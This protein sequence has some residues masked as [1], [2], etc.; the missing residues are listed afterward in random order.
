MQK[1]L[2]AWL[3]AI[4][5]LAYVAVFA[6]YPL[7]RMLAASVGWPDFQAEPYQRLW[8]EP[9]YGLIGQR[10]FVFGLEVTLI[11][12]LIGYP[13]A[14][15]LS[16]QA[17]KGRTYL[18][19]AV[20]IPYLTSLLV[21]TYAWILLL[22]DS[23]PI[24]AVLLTLGVI[25][26]PLMLLFTRVGALIGAVHIALPL[27]IL[28][29]YSV[30]RTMDKSLMRAALSL[31]SGPVR[32]F[33]KVY[34][35]Q[36]VPGIVS[37]V[38]LVFVLVLGFYVIPAALGG[39]GDTLLSNVVVNIIQYSQ[40][41]AMASAVSIALLVVTLAVYLGL[42]QFDRSDNRAFRSPGADR[43]A[44]AALA[45]AT[46]ALLRLD[47]LAAVGW[48]LRMGRPDR[49]A[50]A[51][52]AAFTIGCVSILLFLILP[53][54]IVLGMSFS[55]SDVVTFPPQELSLRWYRQIVGDRSW[56]RAFVFSLEMAVPSA[57]CAL[58]LGSLAAYGLVRMRP[59]LAKLIL[60]L[61]L[62]PMIVPSVVTGVG[63]FGIFN[64][65]GILGTK[66]AI[67]LTHVVIGIPYAV[68]ISYATLQRFDRRL[69][70][71]A[72]SLGASH[73]RTVL[74]VVVPIITS[75]LVAAGIF[76]FMS[77]FDEVIKTSFIA[78]VN[79]R[80][81]PLKIWD[82]IVFQ[83]DPSTAA[84]SSLLLFFPLIAFIIL[85]RRIVA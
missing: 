61:L 18:V 37:G 41:F 78:G 53:N 47:R 51:W 67:F 40:D 55:A 85:R 5:A 81:L 20:G 25:D 17:D 13:V 2:S 35:P 59:R 3:L 11:A 23:G 9:S 6:L 66:F 36:T 69:E 8:N 48:R 46:S 84:V 60:A 70:L 54:L 22:G 50:V 71:A 21:R 15:F 79:T 72:L 45:A 29:I 68:L 4:P 38:T 19:V 27:M 82:N 16:R 74:K 58:V 57:L 77:S 42:S 80:T 76:A 83:T 52:R 63:L 62:L 10:T 65:W 44:L 24:N 28:P 43:K 32:A 31:G 75:G 14:A 7:A 56:A 26:Q 64:D 73:A 49:A 1:S 34:L 30:M 33:F 39:L 12:L